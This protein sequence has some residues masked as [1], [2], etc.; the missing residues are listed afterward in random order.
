MSDIAPG[1]TDSNKFR[2][3]ALE[4]AEKQRHKKL[5]IYKEP[6]RTIPVIFVPGVM[7]SNLMD[8]N[9]KS[10]WRTDDSLGLDAF[11]SWGFRG[12]EKRKRLLDPNNTFVD[13][14]GLIDLE[15]YNEVEQFSTRKLRGWG[16]IGHM[17]YGEF[18]SWLQTVLNDHL[19]KN[20]NT[21]TKNGK[22]TLREKLVTIDLNAEKG[23][24]ESK[25]VD[26]DL[27][28]KYL[29]PVHVVGYN[30]LQSNEK[31]AGVLKEKTE[32]IVKG[33][34]S[35]NMLCEK[36]ILVTHSMGG[37]VARHY[38]ENLGGSNTILGIVHGVMPTLGSPLT[39]KRM[40]AGEAGGVGL[41]IGSSGEQMTAVLA[42]APGPLQLLPGKSYGMGWL[43]IEGL[44]EGL[45]KTDPFEEIYIKKDVWWG[46]CEDRFI[47]PEFNHTNK[48]L[49]DISWVRYKNMIIEDVQPF[50]EMLDEK[51]HENTYVFYGND[52]IK[53]PSYR[54]I[55]WKNY[56][57]GYYER[58]KAGNTSDIAL[59]GIIIDHENTEIKD[60]RT[61]YLVDSQDKTQWKKKSYIISPPCDPGDG[62]VP[63]EGAKFESAGL[64][65]M[66]GVGVDHEGAFK[67]TN[68]EDARLFTLRSIIKISQD[69][70]KTK[71]AYKS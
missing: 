4:M 2:Y 17:S 1:A 32:E 44:K 57:Y 50:I 49:L 36:V 29:F 64:K 8:A 5:I 66:L 35:R 10:I 70:T 13:P 16:E 52:G 20:E 71:L 53:Y 26:T 65:A 60:V 3:Y 41:V 58:N 42:Q 24:Q 43:R 27:T 37:F 9:G 15:Q 69:V 59:R 51:F 38:S 56:S 54:H 21:R 18:L 23:E 55:N 11:Y 14:S 45:P 39:Y 33:Y 31:S 34:N 47:N 40:K 62:T 67:S 61:A 22:K 30:W 68:T 63:V 28:Y 19:T 6:V 46:L 7:G 48:S 12:A 25:N